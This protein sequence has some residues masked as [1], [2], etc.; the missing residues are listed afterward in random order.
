MSQLNNCEKMTLIIYIRG[1][2][3]DFEHEINN[4]KTKEEE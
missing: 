1:E 2:F 4:H 3:N